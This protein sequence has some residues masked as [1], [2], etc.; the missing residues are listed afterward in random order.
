MTSDRKKGKKGE[1]GR[2][3][4]RKEGRR[5]IER[6]R[7]RPRGGA[8]RGKVRPSESRV[9]PTKREI[10][11]SGRARRECFGK[12]HHNEGREARADG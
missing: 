8:E 10:K 2:K 5:E 1:Q 12:L 11:G 4:A 3:D 6:G 9:E 7:R